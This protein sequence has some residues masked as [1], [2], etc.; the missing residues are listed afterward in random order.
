[1]TTVTVN[2][3]PLQYQPRTSDTLTDVINIIQS[4]NDGKE[5]LT[6]FV[7][8]GELFE[9]DQEHAIYRKNVSKCSNI[10]FFFKRPIDLAFEALDSSSSYIDLISAKLKDLVVLYNEK[11]IAEANRRFGEVIEFMDLFIQLMSRIHKT[12]REDKKEKFVKSQTIQNLEVHLLSVLKALIP[13]KE[14]EDIVILC[15]LLEYELMDNLTQWKIKAI[16]E[17]KQFKKM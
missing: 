7:V 3:R 5:V 13:A 1:M 10:E 2:N 15:D 14:K 4:G 11:N 17:L 16:P 12:I 8:D 6:S 9:C